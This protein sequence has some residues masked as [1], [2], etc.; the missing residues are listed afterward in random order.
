MTSIF[1]AFYEVWTQINI[2]GYGTSLMGLY[3]AVLIAF[4][5]NRTVSGLAWSMLIVA[6]LLL[7]MGI[8]IDIIL[9]AMITIGVFVQIRDLV[10]TMKGE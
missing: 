3:I 7:F 1:E 10:I 6:I 4:F 2:F 8:Q 9:I 5:L